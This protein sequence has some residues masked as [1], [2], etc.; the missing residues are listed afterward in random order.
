MHLNTP[1]QNSIDEYKAMLMGE[2]RSKDPIS[3]IS[4]KAMTYDEI[5]IIEEAEPETESVRAVIIPFFLLHTC[6]SVSD[7][8][9]KNTA[10]KSNEISICI[11]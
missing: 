7:I 8:F 10:P 9:G 1:L 2:G 3:H 11:T 4:E 5:V 6:T